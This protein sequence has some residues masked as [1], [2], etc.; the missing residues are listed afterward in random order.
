MA[1]ETDGRREMPLGRGEARHAMLA[2]KSINLRDLDLPSQGSEPSERP[3]V[4][5][6]DI[7]VPLRD[8][9]LR[10]VEL[11]GED[12]DIGD[13]APDPREGLDEERLQQRPGARPGSALIA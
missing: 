4:P 8:G 2:D 1:Q 7:P 5:E 6:R 3:V 11:G 10:V 9:D 13:P 12:I